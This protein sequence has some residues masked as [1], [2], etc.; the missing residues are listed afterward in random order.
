MIKSGKTNDNIK[1]PKPNYF[2]LTGILFG[3]FIVLFV[4]VL[5]ETLGTPFVMDQYAWD[6]NTA[7]IVVGV[8]LSVGGILSI[9]SF[10]ASGY[11]SK[12]I[13]ERK[14][15][16]LVG[17]LPTIIGTFLF[18]PFAGGDIKMQVC[19]GD[20]STNSIVTTEATTSINENI[21]LFNANYKISYLDTDE[22]SFYNSGGHTT[23]SNCSLGCPTSQEWCRTENK[24]EIPQLTV[25]FIIV[26]LGYPIANSLSQSIFSKM[27]GP[28]PQG[29]WMGILTGVGSLSRV[30]G[31][32]F[33]SY[34]Y[35]SFGTTVTFA[36][37]TG[38]MV[39]AMVELV[40]LYKYLVPMK[41][42]DLSP[43]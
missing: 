41:I 36:I 38:T 42:P 4:F 6:D 20:N 13:D 24:L 39:F 7:M 29:I 14:V 9:F 37:M 2:G 5:I 27:L 22:T 40:I 32:I 16:L 35:T 11:L 10:I 26:I 12:K 3:F 33:V 17:L 30:T 21:P 34:V 43:K 18:I 8:A 28:K 1:L 19:E 31:P 15:M 25:A 23:G